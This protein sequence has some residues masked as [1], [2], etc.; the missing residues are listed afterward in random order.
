MKTKIAIQILELHLNWDGGSI[1]LN[2]Q[3]RSA[4]KG[5]GDTVS[6]GRSYHGSSDVN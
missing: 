4:F 6:A 3:V 1:S 2:Y 5:S